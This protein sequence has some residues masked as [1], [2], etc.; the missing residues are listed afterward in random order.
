MF[1]GIHRYCSCLLFCTSPHKALH[2]V[3]ALLPLKLQ[4]DCLKQYFKNP[5]NLHNYISFKC[6]YGATTGSSHFLQPCLMLLFIKTA[7][8]EAAC[9]RQVISCSAST[10]QV[11][12]KPSLSRQLP[13]VSAIDTAKYG[14]SEDVPKLRAAKKVNSN[15]KIRTRRSSIITIMSNSPS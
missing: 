14:M 4:S 3:P 9:T 2:L 13:Q 12:L 15:F 5:F 11:P 1:G 10:L 7:R 6:I 8:A